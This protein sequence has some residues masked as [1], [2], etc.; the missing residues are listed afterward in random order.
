MGRDRDSTINDSGDEEQPVPVVPAER[1]VV[2]DYAPGST[3]PLVTLR[4]LSLIEAEMAKVRLEAEGIPAFIADSAMSLN[5]PLVLPN[6]Q[7]Q[8][9]ETHLGPADEILSR[10]ADD[11]VEGEYADEEYRCPKCHRK[12]VELL[13]LATGPRRA[14]AGCLSLAGV[15]LAGMLASAVI[16]AGQAANAV[17]AVMAWS[18]L[19]WLLVAALGITWILSSREKR[20]IECGHVWGRQT[21]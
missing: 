17:N 2:L 8:V 14:R 13:P 16:P 15:L 1:P 19:G 18:G 7:L 12:A 21:S 3:P 10:P 20:C 9:L 4:R 6:V 5:N 11:T